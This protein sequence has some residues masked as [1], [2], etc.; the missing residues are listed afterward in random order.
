M[1]DQCTPCATGQVWWPC[2]LVGE[3][4]CK[5][6]TA[7]EEEEE[8]EAE[9]IKKCD[10][11]LCEPGVTGQFVVPFTNCEQYVVCSGGVPGDIQTCSPGQAFMPAISAC[12]ILALVTCPEDPTCPPTG[13]PTESPVAALPTENPT[14]DP[15]SSSA[16]TSSTIGGVSSNVGGGGG[17][18]VGGGGG[19]APPPTGNDV[20]FES[21]YL[22]T[23]PMDPTVLEG[24]YVMDAHMAAN[25]IVLTRELLTSP[26]SARGKASNDF[27]YMGFRS[28]L[29]TMITTG[30]SNQTFYIG[31]SGVENGRAYGL[32]NIAAFLAM[33]VEDSIAHGSCDEVNQDIVGGLLPISNACGQNGMSYQDMTCPRGEEMY[34]C[35]VDPTMRMV[36]NNIDA[37]ARSG[38]GD[39]DIPPKPFYCGP[40]SDYEG[41]YTGHWDYVSGTEVGQPPVENGMERQDV[42]GCCW[43]GRGSIQIRGTCAYGKLNYHLGKRAH[44]EGRPSM[45]PDIDF[46]RD[47][48]A[49]CSH[50]QYP[51]LKWIAGMFRWITEI[52][53]YN[54]GEF[55]YMQRLIDFV[56]GGLRDWTFVHGLSGIVAQGCHEPP[57]VEGAEFDG[58]DRKATFIRTLR[59]LGLSVDDGTATGRRLGES[60]R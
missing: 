26:G 28:S 56:D 30:V 11:P 59:L 54:Q 38:G 58:A 31:H 7:V 3:C 34:T 29:H 36:A 25:K 4:F 44:D 40:T 23:I 37:N 22:P 41:G 1:D 14:N 6:L 9:V 16:P 35:E 24:M 27:S 51:D 32:V 57:C 15:T 17:A 43:W 5:D 10:L 18:T 13:S 8:E 42:E 50:K 53:A 2:N 48:Q 46:C 60:N 19:G 21:S 20:K 55:S 33:S 47:P 52:Q 12:N 39:G 49:I 45:Y